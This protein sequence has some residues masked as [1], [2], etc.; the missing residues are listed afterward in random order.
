VRG[1]L[2]RTILDGNALAGYHSTDIDSRGSAAGL[3]LC[4][5]KAGGFTKTIN[6]IIRR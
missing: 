6:V 2:V 4:T 1:K 5:M 3:Y